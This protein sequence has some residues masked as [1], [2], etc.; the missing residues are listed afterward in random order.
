[1]DDRLSRTQLDPDPA[2]RFVSLRRALGITSFGMNQMVLRPGERGRIH[3]HEHQEEVY[4]VLEGTLTLGVAGE[5]VDLGP[6]EVARVPPG[7]RRQ[8][9]NRHRTRVVL[10]AL[11]G[12]GEHQGRDASAFTT[13]DDPTPVPPLELPLP[14]DLPDSELTP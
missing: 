13:W 3:D 7:V 11:G 8:V 10:I 1:M 4:L 6:G 5:E 9:S 12:H 2:D 14:D